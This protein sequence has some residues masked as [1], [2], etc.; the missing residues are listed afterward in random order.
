MTS[1]KD[2]LGK[3][4]EGYERP[5]P[6][7]V[8]PGND[9]DPQIAAL[10]TYI[11]T[12]MD[13]PSHSIILDF[14]SG[15]GLLPHWLNVIWPQDRGIPAY[16]AVDLNEPLDHL[17]LPIRVHNN[18]RKVP[19]EE[20][21]ESYLET[22]GSRIEL[23]VIRNVLHEMGLRDTARLFSCLTSKLKP[24]TELYVQDMVNLPRVEPGRAGWDPELL[25][26]LFQNLGAN[27]EQIALKSHGGTRWFALRV[28]TGSAPVSFERTIQ[29]CAQTRSA[30]RDRL[31]N[32]VK[33]L[34][35]QNQFDTSYLRV[36]LQNDVTTI[37]LQ[38]ETEVADD[39]RPPSPP[40]EAS[41]L[42][43]LGLLL[44]VSEAGPLDYAVKAIGDVAR[45]GGLLA[46]LSNKRMLDIADVVARAKRLV[47]FA[48][49]SQHSF[50][51]DPRMPRVIEDLLSE[52]KRI[53]LLL[54]DPTSFAASARALVPAYSDPQDLPRAIRMTISAATTQHKA[55]VERLGMDR[56]HQYFELAVT[57][58]TPP[59]SY[60][61]VDDT[62]IASLYS[63]HLTG[64]TGSCF[65]FRAGESATNSYYRV[66]RDDFEATWNS[67]ITTRLL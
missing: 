46:V 40:I 4:L 61:I 30:Q 53:R 47:C 26:R 35:Q 9:G 60:F 44:R 66:L 49:Y 59:C 58:W 57:P 29:L 21:Y 10:T 20:F 64:S 15:D 52:S 8:P 38:L 11:Q 13:I 63:A 14:G 67:P 48:G 2:Q 17:R 41:G 3:F 34:N 18:S 16:H 62:C 25:S 31:L 6:P 36:V 42:S 37:S 56:V 19:L 32:E 28:K 54:V 7:Q 1:K 39:G 50:F 27:A 23:V 5:E 12:K 24:G 55:L 22:T 33:R 65:V 51:E 45:V 43:S